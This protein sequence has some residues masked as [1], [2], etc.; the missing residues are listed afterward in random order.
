MGSV[1]WLSYKGLK[2]AT[3]ACK[4]SHNPCDLHNTCINTSAVLTQITLT[5]HTLIQTQ[6][7]RHLLK[8]KQ[9]HCN[10]MLGKIKTKWSVLEHVCLHTNETHTCS[11]HRFTFRQLWVS[12]RYFLMNNKQ[13]DRSHHDQINSWDKGSILQLI[14][15]LISISLI[16][17]LPL[18]PIHCL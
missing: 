4:Q 8:D 6:H 14:V 3:H 16:T 10:Q 12:M 9:S 11:R 7:K 15:I 5:A 13:R 1:T 18:N 17:L 2:T